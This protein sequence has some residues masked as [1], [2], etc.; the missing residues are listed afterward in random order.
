MCVGG[1]DLSSSVAF[2]NVPDFKL[3]KRERQGNNSLYNLTMQGTMG[4]NFGDNS[5][6]V[7][8]ASLLIV[9]EVRS[10]HC[11]EI[12]MCILQNGNI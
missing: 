11:L 10:E 4:F 1:F 7:K 6:H 5:F 8:F 9:G 12:W 3:T 2:G